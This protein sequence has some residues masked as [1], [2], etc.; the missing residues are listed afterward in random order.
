MARKPNIERAAELSAIIAKRYPLARP[1]MVARYVVAAQRASLRAKARAE[2]LCEYEEAEGL[3]KRRNA[4]EDRA[5]R[6]FLAGLREALALQEGEEG[7]ALELGG[8]PR[9]PCGR[10]HI[11]GLQGDGWGAGFAVY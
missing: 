10:L 11:P 8:D 5:E 7:P 2:W 3:A 9:G 6:A 4:A 1:H